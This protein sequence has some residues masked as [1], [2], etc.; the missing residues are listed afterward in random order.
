MICRPQ[1]LLGHPLGGFF[2]NAN[3]YISALFPPPTDVLI[4]KP[5]LEF[6]TVWR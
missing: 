5:Y 4:V 3:C 6:S 2:M 1:E